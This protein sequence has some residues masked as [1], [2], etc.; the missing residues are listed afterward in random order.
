[1]ANPEGLKGRQPRAASLARDAAQTAKELADFLE[2]YAELLD[3]PDQEALVG[4]LR[5]AI[6]GR[7]ATLRDAVRNANKLQEKGGGK[8]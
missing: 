3:A 1:M 8:A 5:E 4:E 6:S 2:E 7:L